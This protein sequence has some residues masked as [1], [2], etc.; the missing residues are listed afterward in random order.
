MSAG[1]KGLE[2]R[3][4]ATLSN[5]GDG[6]HADLLFVNP[7]GPEAADRIATLEAALKPFDRYLG[8]DDG[9]WSDDSTVCEWIGP[10]LR[11]SI[12]FRDLRAARAAL[13]AVEG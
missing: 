2:D 10:A 1:M 9:F 4:R 8:E 5:G 13:A 11:V 7:D 3:L 6:D 12:S